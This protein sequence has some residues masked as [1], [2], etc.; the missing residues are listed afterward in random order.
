MPPYTT[1]LVQHYNG[2]QSC[3]HY[4]PA[5]SSTRTGRDGRVELWSRG[6][7]PRAEDV[8]AK[9][10]D[11]LYSREDGVW[12]PD[13]LHPEMVWRGSGAPADSGWGLPALFNPFAPV[14]VAAAAQHF[15]ER[16]G[17]EDAE[18]LQPYM[19]CS[20]G[21]KDVEATRSNLAIARQGVCV[22]MRARACVCVLGG[23]VC[24]CCVG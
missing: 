21:P 7:V 17:G 24:S 1:S 20:G 18:R 10:V 16:L 14:P 5:P 12:Y 6:K 4:L 3:P 13:G 19:H 9:H 11:S 2:H 15:T 8:G 23:C 22:C